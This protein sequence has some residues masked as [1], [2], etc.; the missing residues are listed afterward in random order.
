MNFKL[1]AILVNSAKLLCRVFRL[2]CLKSKFSSIYDRL[3][4]KNSIKRF[5]LMENS[6]VPIDGGAYW[7]NSFDRRLMD[8][9]F[10]AKYSIRCEWRKKKRKWVLLTDW[11]FFL[12]KITNSN[13]SFWPF[14]RFISCNS[15]KTNGATDSAITDS[16]I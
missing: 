11:W 2:M 5:N 7:R 10:L 15:L 4:C 14:K 8:R 16:T 1:F 9:S 6:N 12:V 13:D 3:N